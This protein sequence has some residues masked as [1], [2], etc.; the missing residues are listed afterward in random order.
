MENKVMTVQFQGAVLYGF[1]LG[2]NIY[3][4]IKPIADALGLDWE[5]QRAR[6]QR[7]PVLSESTFITKVPSPKGPQNTLCLLLDYLNGWLFKIQSA[8]I[9]DEA[10]RT[11]I[12]AFQRECYQVLNRHFC[13]DRDKLVGEANDAMSL[14]L[15]LCQ[16]CRHI[17]GNRAAD[18]LWIKLGLP[19]VPAMEEAFRQ[20]ELFSYSKAA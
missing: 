7:D 13:G 12:Q 20:G 9:P 14:H 10:I 19:R 2:G 3:V 15:R 6:I 11:K 5:A 8:R 1:Q 4:A 17:H 16:E 18:Q